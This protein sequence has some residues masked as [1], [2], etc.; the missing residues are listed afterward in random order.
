[1]FNAA[2]TSPRKNAPASA[3]P[4]A[5]LQQQLIDARKP[6]EAPPIV[7]CKAAWMPASGK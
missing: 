3:M 4:C 2:V 6:V 7:S 5:V 1:M